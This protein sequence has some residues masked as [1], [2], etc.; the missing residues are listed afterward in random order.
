MLLIDEVVRE[1]DAPVLYFHAKGVSHLPPVPL[2]EAWR[3]YLNQY[4]GEA[5][6]WA[7]LLLSQP[8][9][10]ACG[11]LKLHENV[12]GFTYFAGNFWMAKAAYMRQ[13]PP[14]AE[15]MRQP[16]PST[17]LPPYHRAL[18]EVAV[19]RTQSMKGLAADNTDLTHESVWPYLRQVL[20]QETGKSV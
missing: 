10:D 20:A 16:V 12:N 3:G 15:F 2:Y 9:Y 7:Q 19:N 4:V 13:L 11:P 5:D 8:G 17:Y 18:A 6:G 14:Y 1:D